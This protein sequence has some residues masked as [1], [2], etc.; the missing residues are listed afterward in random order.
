M[1]LHF[2]RATDL[3]AKVLVNVQDKAFYADYVK[4]GECPGY[5]KSEEKMRESLTKNQQYKI[6]VDDIVIG[7]VSAH[8]KEGVC[9]LDCLCVMPEYE[10]KGIGQKAVVF[11]EK[12][13][14]QANSWALETP[15]DKVRNHY[16]YKK[17]G[18]DIVGERMDGNVAIM[19]FHKVVNLL[20]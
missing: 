13:Y 19:I 12:Q 11:I 14:P 9:H 5:G 16:F 10:N 17:C 1:E 8:E 6:I 18:Y 4:Y 3:D 7:K 2:E 20:D 15:K